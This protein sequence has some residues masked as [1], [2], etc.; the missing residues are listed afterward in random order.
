MLCCPGTWNFEAHILF[1]QLLTTEKCPPFD[2]FCAQLTAEKSKQVYCPYLYDDLYSKLAM[3]ILP[4]GK[5][6][7]EVRKTDEPGLYMV[8]YKDQRK[9]G[10]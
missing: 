6:G 2:F 5:L 10:D 8:L 1:N 7:T 9:E 3:F 4:F